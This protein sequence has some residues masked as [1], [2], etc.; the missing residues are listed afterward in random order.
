[1]SKLDVLLQRGFRNAFRER[2]IEIPRGLNKKPLPG[3][4]ASAIYSRLGELK[5]KAVNLDMTDRAMQ[6]WRGMRENVSSPPPPRKR[7]R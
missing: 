5:N 2:N 6:Q 7:K 4:K 3:M 1:M